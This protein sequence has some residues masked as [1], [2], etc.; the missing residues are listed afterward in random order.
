MLLWLLGLFTETP[1]LAYHSAMFTQSRSRS[2]D[3]P[4]PSQS[5]AQTQHVHHSLVPDSC[6]VPAVGLPWADQWGW[7]DTA[8]NLEWQLSEPQSGSDGSGLWLWIY[9]YNSV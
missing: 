5:G 9:T 2:C 6:A 4:V 7:Y 3:L 8:G 1:E